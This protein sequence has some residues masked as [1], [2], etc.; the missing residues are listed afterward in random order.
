MYRTP[1]LF[2]MPGGGGDALETHAAHTHE[3]GLVVKSLIYFCIAFVVFRSIAIMLT[4]L[5]LPRWRPLLTSAF[6]I[7]IPLLTFMTSKASPREPA[8]NGG[9]PGDISQQP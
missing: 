1:Q 5:D 8:A 4:S 3:I 9:F 7:L 2:A 6:F